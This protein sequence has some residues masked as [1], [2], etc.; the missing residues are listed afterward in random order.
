MSAYQIGFVMEQALGHVTHT[1]NLQAT[2][3]TDP[4]IQAYW[5]LIP[6]DADGLSGHIPLYKSNWTVRAGIRARAA[7]KQMARRTPLDGLFFHTQV[8]AILA[9]DWVKRYPSIVSLDATPLQYDRLG[10][11]YRH[12]TGPV[13]LE[14]MKW[15]LNRD[16]YLAARH[17][18]TWSRWARQGLID[19]YEVPAEKVTVI[20]PGVDVSEWARPT[21][22]ERNSGPVRI[23]FVG[24]NLERKGGSLLLQAFRA[25]RPLGVE[26]HLVTK[27]PVAPEPGIFVYN[28]LQPNSQPLKDLYHKCDIFTLPTSG[29]CLPMVL[30]EAGAAGMAVV[31]TRVAA[32]PEVVRHEDTGLTIPPGDAQALE[33]ALRRLVQQPDLR[34]RFGER[35]Q[36]H[37]ARDYDVRKNANDLIDL[38]KV[39]VETA[40]VDVRPA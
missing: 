12:D 26:L 33:E 32:I 28:D 23:L 38:L 9:A 16:C 11:F 1:K 10:E 24:G 21:P 22:R 7:L 29:D 36:A 19:E 3:K 5:A 18:V 20:P 2:I 35:A 8:P 6:F 31:S 17:L 34:L 30:S 13:W 4:G 37:I 39:E 14:R 25:L 40:Q 27:D 15:G